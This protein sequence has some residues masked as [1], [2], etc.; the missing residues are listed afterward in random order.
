MGRHNDEIAWALVFRDPEN[1]KRW[2]CPYC[3]ISS[4]SSVTRVKH[5][6]AKNNNAGISPFPRVP[7]EVQE[8]A[9]LLL[10]SKVAPAPELNGKNLNC[11]NFI[12]LIK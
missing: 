10:W 1:P 2:T 7:G 12:F 4:S 5:H 8:L 6:L 3:N 11:Y 9:R